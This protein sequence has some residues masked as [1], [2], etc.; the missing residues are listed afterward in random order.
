MLATDDWSRISAGYS[1][2]DDTKYYNITLSEMYAAL[3]G[4]PLSKLICNRVMAWKESKRFLL[5]QTVAMPAPVM[6]APMSHL[7]IESFDDD[8]DEADLEDMT[9][10]YIL[11]VPDKVPVKLSPLEDVHDQ[12]EDMEHYLDLDMRKHAMLLVHE[13]LIHSS[14]PLMVK[15]L[16]E[17]YRLR[18]PHVETDCAAHYHSCSFCLPRLK[19]VRNVG[20]AIRAVGRFDSVQIDTWIKSHNSG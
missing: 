3:S 15:L 5:L 8:A 13:C 19:A 10:Q 9:H 2:D 1:T 7:I 18:W 17:R 6:V 20:F 4:Q 11:V 14:P 12:S 16:R